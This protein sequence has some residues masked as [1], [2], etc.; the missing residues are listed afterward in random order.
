MKTTSLI[1][2][3]AFAGVCS[4]QAQAASPDQMFVT[5]AAQGGIAEVELGTVANTQGASAEVKQF[6][7]R[8]VTD[9]S[10]ANDA[11]KQAAAKSGANV[12]AEP[13]PVQK[14][15]IAKLKAMQG[16]AFDGA[17]ASAMVKDHEEDVALFEHESTSG[18]D[19][20]L[21]TF[22]SDTLPVLKEHLKMAQALPGGA[23]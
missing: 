4:L 22:A 14:A 20:A 7:S 17:Y 23:K 21:R 12:P 2:A 6:G 10:K 16:A 11:L 8:M 13:S 5:K 3:L 1:L 9:H 19:P 15:S 18:Q